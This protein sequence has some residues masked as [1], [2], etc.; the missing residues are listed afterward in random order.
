MPDNAERRTTGSCR[1]RRS[2]A[3]SARARRIIRDSVLWR[4]RWLVMRAGS[5]RSL[6]ATLSTSDSS[7]QLHLLWFR[8][9]RYRRGRRW[10]P[11]PEP[12]PLPEPTP[13]ALPMSLLE[14]MPP[15]LPMIDALTSTNAASR[16]RATVK[17]ETLH[18]MHSIFLRAIQRVTYVCSA[19]SRS[20]A[21]CG[22]FPTCCLKS[23]K[24]SLPSSRAKH[25][26]VG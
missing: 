22:I 11:L 10:T 4:S 24:L 26:R 16:T 8:P 5:G 25:S 2:W 23:S 7:S 13:S 18:C 9:S 12:I 20:N 14:P 19:S 17:S 3:P 21:P 1:V 15:V 6:L